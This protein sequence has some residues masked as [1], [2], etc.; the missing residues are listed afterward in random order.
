MGR[1]KRGLALTLVLLAAE[2]A[3][4]QPPPRDAP[5]V[6]GPTASGATLRVYDT[7]SGLCGTVRSRVGRGTACD[8]GGRLREP[9][10]SFDP[11]ARG[12]SIAWGFV[13]PEVLA[14][15]IV[16]SGGRRVQ[17][18]TTDGPA[19]TG[20]HAGKVRF[21]LAEIDLRRG[22]RPLYA[23]LLGA[24]GGLL[25]AVDAGHDDVRV[26][27]GHTIARG[28][29]GP[30]RWRFEATLKRELTPLPG[31][32]ERLADWPCVSL[33]ATEREAIGTE[34]VTRGEACADPD[35]AAGWELGAERTC[36]RLGLTLVG[37]APPEARRLVAV[38]GDGRPC[39]C[40]S[41]RF[42]GASAGVVRSC[43]RSAP[44]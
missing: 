40:R 23:R 28:R 4:A 10:L 21:F 6:A 20:R 38:K 3:A 35:A 19:Y 43:W 7:R 24:G 15:E 25:A 5:I 11:S 37:L 31:E 8:G 29:V 14:V 32:E 1:V 42:Q 33:R 26:G 36:A 44:G 9:L 30:V 12:P 18:P 2:A 13:A 17:V 27:P 22:E 34:L 39:A 41:A 16:Y